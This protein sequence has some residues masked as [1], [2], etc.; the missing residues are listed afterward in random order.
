MKSYKEKFENMIEVMNKDK[1]I[2]FLHINFGAPAPTNLLEK[3]GESLSNDRESDI[4]K[5]YSEMNGLQIIWNYEDKINNE[6]EFKP[7]LFLNKEIQFDG[8]I[9][10]LPL[11]IFLNQLTWKGTVWFED[12][13]DI[14][15]N[16]LGEEVSIKM[17]RKKLLPFDLFSTDMSM[18]LFS[19]STNDY[20]LLLQDYHIDYTNSLIAYF[21]DYVALILKTKGLVKSRFEIF[22]A[23][24][25]YRK[26]VIKAAQ[27]IQKL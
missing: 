27:L 11:E 6:T 2:K 7:L 5:F 12:D 10:F 24:N 19:N 23:L 13:K 8:V 22:N 21:D 16:F 14:D 25:G 18:A 1:K 20:V 26:P 4:I 3:A 17:I 15:A 9:N